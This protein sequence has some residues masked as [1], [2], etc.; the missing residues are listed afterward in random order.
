MSPVVVIQ[1]WKIH[2][3]LFGG[4]CG[5]AGLIIS[6]A[7]VAI[8]TGIMRST[9]TVQYMPHDNAEA[10]KPEPNILEENEKALMDKVGKKNKEKPTVVEDLNAPLEEITKTDITF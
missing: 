5:F 3:A 6:M 9:H 4:L 2:L 1:E 8:V 7:C 10:F